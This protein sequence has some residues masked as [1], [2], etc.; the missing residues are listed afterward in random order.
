MHKGGCVLLK[1]TDRIAHWINGLWIGVKG[2]AVVCRLGCLCLGVLVTACTF[3]STPVGDRPFVTRQGHQ[4][5]LGS[6]SF[7]FAGIHAP[8]L[9]RIEQDARGPCKADPRGWGQYFK[10]PTAKEQENWIK[11]LTRS[12][13]RAMRIYVLSVYTPFDEACEREVHILPP[14]IAGGRP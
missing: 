8:E 13:H 14:R 12:G 9:H 7:R 2:V 3:T 4:L 5:K 11:A 10:W 6:E 1:R